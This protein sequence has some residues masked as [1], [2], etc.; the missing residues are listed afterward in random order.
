[1]PGLVTTN[2]TLHKNPLGRVM[3]ILLANLRALQM[4]Q[5]VTEWMEC[6]D[7]STDQASHKQR[8][9]VVSDL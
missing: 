6:Q 5:E 2:F 1:M 7:S 3:K 4:V 8:T 9:S